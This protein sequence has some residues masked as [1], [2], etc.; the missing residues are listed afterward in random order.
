MASFQRVFTTLE[1]APLPAPRPE[2]TG[3]I[4]SR[5]LP[6]LVRRR[7]IAALGWTYAAALVMC[8][9]LVALWRLAPWSHRYVAAIPAGVS[10]GLLGAGLFVLNA[11]GT[12]VVHLA[13]GLRWMRVAGE[14]LAPV[15][16]ALEAVL[17][18]PG[19]VLT[20][21]AA[22]A[23]CVALLWWMRPRPAP[24]VREVRHVSVLGF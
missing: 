2:L 19:I 17:G 18:Q 4:L 24:A 15:S 1:R 6:S 13:D 8:G 7:R 3:R 22:A 5:V 14:R 21:W 9:G 11:L 12:S 16:R 10:R 20:A 23:A